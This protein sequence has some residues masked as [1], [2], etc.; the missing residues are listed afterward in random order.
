M[1][2][3][4]LATI[5]LVF[6]TGT[7]R[8]ADPAALEEKIKRLEQQIAAQQLLLE[9]LKTEV[10]NGARLQ[11]DAAAAAQAETRKVATEVAQKEIGQELKK[12][13][14]TGWRFFGDTRLRFDGTYWDE[15]AFPDR[16]YFRLRAR[17]GVSKTFGHGVSGTIRL[18]TGVNRLTASPEF[19]GAPASPNQNL[20]ES[21]DRKG[22]LLDQAFITWTPEIGE[23][24]LTLGGGKFANP[25]LSTPIIWDV[26]VNP[27]GFYQ[28]FSHKF[29]AVEPFFTLG[30]M[31]IRENPLK[32][33]AFALAGQ[34]GVN[35][36]GSAAS[37][38]LAVSYY[39]YV[40]YDSDYKYAGGNTISLVDN[41]TVLN[42]GDFNVV[43]FLAR[44]KIDRWRYPVEVFVD[45]AR[46]LGAAGPYADQDTAWS[47]GGQIGRN[48]AQRDWSVAYRY[49]SIEA[50]AVPGAF[51]DSDFG[52]ANRKGSEAK[53]KYNIYDPLTIGATLYVTD[54]T[55]MLV[56][57]S[58]TRLQ[59]DFEYKF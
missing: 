37:L 50:N 20:A 28:K 3:I 6:L 44:G 15:N 38:S 45:Y 48:R 34:G 49:A 29:G 14:L 58:W 30:E 46:N 10:R 23:R 56:R 22:V 2:W 54:P 9:E 51:C 52:Y 7:P 32:D 17:L 42:A 41:T 55:L 53:F 4:P 24:F 18:A 21:F 1:K 59:V 39:D 27:E 31:I 43:E 26:D 13:N 8:G 40:R 25:Y 12:T 5:L 19:G 16:N 57:E 33:D 36:S 11:A 47:I 35:V